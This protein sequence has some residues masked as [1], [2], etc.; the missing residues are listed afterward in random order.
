MVLESIRKKSKR[1]LVKINRAHQIE[2]KLNNK[3]RNYMSKASGIS[4]FTYNWALKKW[5]EWYSEGKK[6]SPYALKKEFNAIK[7]QEFPFVLAVTKCSPEQAFVDLGKA[8]KSFFQGLKSKK[9]VGFPKFKKRGIRDSFYL[10]NDQF[11]IKGKKIRIPKLGWVKLREFWR[12]PEDRILS[13]TVSKRADK[14]FISINS[15]GNIEDT[16]KPENYIGVDVGIK[17]LAVVSDGQ[18]FKNPKP[19]KKLLGRVQLLSKSVFRKKKGSKNREKAKQKL[20]RLHYRISCIRKDVLH[21]ASTAITKCA[22]LIGIEDLNISGMMKNRKLS[23]AISDVGLYEFHRQ[24]EYKSQWHSAVVVKADRFYPSSKTCSNCQNI[25]SDLKLSDRI[26]ICE[27]CDHVMDRD[28][29][30][31]INL[32]NYAVGFTVKAYRPE[33]SGSSSNV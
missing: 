22:T 17:E 26:Y 10:S 31:A 9:K 3:E 19:L 21:K 5:Q 18:V 16:K 33:S 30:A 29:N 23:R 7:R 27:S 2:L 4:R 14:W 20:S 8:F 28:L 12:F 11:K 6:T 13:A 25:K 15:E 32:R 24:I 1:W